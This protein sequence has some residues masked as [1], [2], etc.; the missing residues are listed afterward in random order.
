MPGIPVNVEPGL[1]T[2]ESGPR[3]VA[4]P[5]RR[6][7]EVVANDALG[8]YRVIGVDDADGPTPLPGQF[9]MLSAD[10]GWGSAD[11][12]RP[13]LARAFSVARVRGPRLEFMLEVVGP[14]TRRLGELAPGDRLGIVGPLG[15]G[16]S[17]PGELTGTLAA[18]A[19]LVGG[20]IGTAPLAIWSEELAAQRR[21]VR[22]L[23]GF[24][25]AAFCAG[26]DLIQGEV[27][28]ATDDGSR[29]HHGL[30]TELLES[31]LDS[32]HGEL[33]VY[34]CGPPGMLEAVR[35]I[36]VSRDVPAQL[37]LEA[38]MACGFGACFGCVVRTR[39]GYRRLCVDG[40]VVRADVLHEEWR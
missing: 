10:R 29:G 28:L 32:G 21:S 20:G 18:S 2:P 19:L 13:Y 38:P 33:T 9:Y 40:P 30:V 35:G 17:S 12:G 25:S 16:F 24:R 7:R 27:V 26:A 3:Q 11:G 37:A 14:G 36:C 22:A 34:S 8:P 23:L 39:E 15:I 1:A 6:V 31:Q 4:P 5:A